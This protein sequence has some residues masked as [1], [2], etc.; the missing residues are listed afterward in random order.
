MR[1]IHFAKLLIENELQYK[2]I[3]NTNLDVNKGIDILIIY[4]NKNYGVNLYTKTKR[5]FDGRLKKEK[6]HAL[7]ENI[8]YIELP[9]EF[10]AYK[11]TGD[12][13]LYSKKEIIQLKKYL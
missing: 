1:D 6:R 11:K 7:Y 2:V 13:Y 10:D 4:N 12:F 9:V 5:A 3:Y 8:V